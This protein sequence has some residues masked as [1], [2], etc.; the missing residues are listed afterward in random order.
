[1]KVGVGIPPDDVSDVSEWIDIEEELVN[2][3]VNVRLLE[4][5][6]TT[7]VLVTGIDVEGVVRPE[8]VEEGEG[9][10]VSEALE[11]DDV[12]VVL[13]TDALVELTEK[14]T[15]EV[16]KNVEL[17]EVAFEVT[18]LAETVLVTLDVELASEMDD[19]LQIRVSA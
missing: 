5:L 12:G 17:P 16:D 14:M 2:I 4:R 10:P 19:D 8:F 15:I 3:P 18:V 1:M 13:G 11:N 7:L 9:L 6:V